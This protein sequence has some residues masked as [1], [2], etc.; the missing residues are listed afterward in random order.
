MRNRIL[1]S[2]LILVFF[3]PTGAPACL[4]T[5]GTTIEGMPRMSSGNSLARYLFW[6]L[7]TTPKEKLS[8]L[9]YQ[10]PASQSESSQKERAAVEAI[11]AGNITNGITILQELE[12]AT[13]GLYATA[14]NLGTAYE[15]AGDNRNALKWITEGIA[16]NPES[17][18]GTEWLHQ[19]ILETKLR[20]EADPGYLKT[21]RIIPLPEKFNPDTKI[22]ISGKEYTIRQIEWALNYQL[23]ERVVFVK[24]PDPVVADLLF[25]Y[26]RIEAHTNIVE[27]GVELLHES[28]RYGFADPALL[29]QTEKQYANSVLLG[30]IFKYGTGALLLI[31]IPAGLYICHRKKWF[32]LS[33]SAYLKYKAEKDAAKR[34]KQAAVG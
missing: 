24:P 31:S 15:L 5:G 28:Q 7:R 23:R 6:A 18:G 4:N 20:L 11:L 1:A 17:H 34:A 29:A 19:L 26:A 16:R 3:F 2:A 10:D 33:R 13:P 21:H 27:N 30:K 8:A 9:P 25:S 32:F 14:A 12:N 22:A